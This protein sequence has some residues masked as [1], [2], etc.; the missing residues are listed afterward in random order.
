MKR[1]R[2]VKRI[3]IIADLH[4]GHRAGLTP[5]DYRYREASHE[6]IWRKFTSVQTETWRLY[7]ME[8]DRLRPIDLLIAN[9]DLIDGRGERSGGVELITGDRNEQCEMATECLRLAKAKKIVITRGTPYHA[10]DIESWEDL[11]AEKVAVAD[12][13]GYKPER[14]KIGDREWPE[15]NGYVFDCCHYVGGSSIPH[16][17]SAGIKRDQL[18]QRLWA[19]AK[20]QPRVDCLVRSHVHYYRY[21]EDDET[22]KIQ[23]VVI[24]P[25]LQAMGTRYGAR[26][27]RGTVSWGVL[28]WDINTKGQVVWRHVGRHTVESTKAKVFHV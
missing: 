12:D 9:G 28:A 18:W 10:G 8:I 15:V 5:P 6:H 26:I 19:E 13:T 14:V 20:D 22:G 24:T 25:A 23:S 7:K 17:R 2:G 1:P 21:E 11:V 4:C 16:G 3:V 27:C